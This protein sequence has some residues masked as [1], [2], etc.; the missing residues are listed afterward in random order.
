MI[1][2]LKYKP[3]Y[4][5]LALNFNLKNASAS[6]ELATSA[7]ELSSQAQQLSEVIGFFKLETKSS[8]QK[9]GK[10]LS[11]NGQEQHQGLKVYHTGNNGQN[12]TNKERQNTKLTGN[13]SNNKEKNNGA[14]LQL[15]ESTSDDHFENY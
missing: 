8:K 12:G 5:T 1:T 6:E 4:F 14:D 9:A 3:A 7:E 10:F 2:L 13:T 15:D 11:G